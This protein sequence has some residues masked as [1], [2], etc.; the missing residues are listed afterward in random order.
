MGAACVKSRWGGLRQHGGQSTGGRSRIEEG[1][2]S[3]AARRP[4][5]P[6]VGGVEGSSVNRRCVTAAWEGRGF[7]ARGVPASF[8]VGAAFEAVRAIGAARART[9]APASPSILIRARRIATS[10]E[11]VGFASSHLHAGTADGHGGD[12]LAR[13]HAGGLLAEAGGDDVGR[14]G[15]SEHLGRHDSDAGG[16]DAKWHR[17]TQGSALAKNLPKDQISFG[18]KTACPYA[19]S[20][21]FYLD[22]PPSAKTT[23]VFGFDYLEGRNHQRADRAF[24]LFETRTT[25]NKP[26]FYRSLR[27]GDCLTRWP[28]RAPPR[29]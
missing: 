1:E 2:A 17:V 12:G 22:L 11:S 21:S 9:D 18:T 13:G 28:G 4:P 19:I 23:C 20:G 15:G 25:T 3:R 8:D 16:C 14:H 27:H 7:V 5:P 24:S 6:V 26:L 10:G 29:P